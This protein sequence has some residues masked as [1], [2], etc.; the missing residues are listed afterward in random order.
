[1]T[2]DSG[3]MVLPARTR[4]AT[5][6]DVAARARVSIGTVS[7][8]LNG[9][10][11]KENNR[12]RIDEAVRSLSYTRNAIASAMKSERSN[13]VGLLV[14][15]YDEFHAQ[16]LGQ[17]GKA[18]REKGVVTLTYC[19]EASV[20]AARD[21]L[22]FFDNHR[23]NALI[24]SGSQGLEQELDDMLGR[25]VQVIAYDNDL[26][27]P[28]IDQVKVDNA[29]V[30]QR[31]VE[32]LVGLGHERIAILAGERGVWTAE[33]RLQGYRD[34]LDAAGI[35]FDPALVI[36][37]DWRPASGLEGMRRV[38]ARPGRPSAVFSSNHQMTLGV[39]QF[40][41]ERELRLPDEL[42]VASFDDVELF[43]HVT[44]S[45][46]AIAQPV[47]AIARAIRDLFV[48]RYAT[49]VPSAASTVTLDCELV[50]R[51]STAAPVSPFPR[52]R[53]PARPI[54]G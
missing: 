15:D 12:L 34:A 22:A 24:L 25:G 50:L 11:V 16:L 9:F 23:V 42:S 28:R 52:P 8:H 39:L 37:G 45:I 19:H 29:R 49:D 54:G 33:R 51:D 46:T 35:A 4:A 14:P 10:R 21:S 32:H 17:L 47:P 2:D 48:E 7:R 31:A 13:M 30:S 43:R 5:I 41:R 40:A 38:W 44:P 27:D 18:F 36:D 26:G 20:E 6:G 3:A 53:A 1:M